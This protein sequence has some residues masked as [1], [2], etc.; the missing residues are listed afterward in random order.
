MYSTTD[1]SNFVAGTDLAFYII[2]GIS[3]LFFVSIMVVMLWFVY[4]YDKKRNPTPTEIHGNNKLEILWTVIPTLLALLMFYYGWTAWYPI[5][6]APDN[7]LEIRAV[8]RM[9]S[10]TYEY[11]NGKTSNDLKVPVGRPV[12]I[13]L[14]AQDVLHSVFIPAFRI[15]QDAVPGKDNFVWFISGKEGTYDLFCTEYCGVRHSYMYSEVKVM[16][17][18]GFDKWFN[19]LSD[20]AVTSGPGADPVAAGKKLIESKGC[21]ACHSLDGSK[22][23]GPSFKGIYGKED[24]VLAGGVEKKIKVDDEYIK[25]SIV[26]PNAEVLKGFQAGQMISYK[27]ELNDEQIKAITEFI[28]SLGEK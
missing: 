8:A 26:D 22:I 27:T 28:K 7:A 15:K 19:D 24:I 4:R 14:V 13:N 5:R 9:W 25:R 11:P 23:V 17:Q 6:N 16:P 20:V 10:F 3:A 18:A 12:K 21:I 2:I 1:A